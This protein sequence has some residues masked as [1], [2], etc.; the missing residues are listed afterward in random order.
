MLR[1]LL[2]VAL[3]VVAGVADSR[4]AGTDLIDAVKRQDVTAARSLVTKHPDIN[5]TDA[6][7]LTALHWAVQRDNVPLVELLIRSGANVRLTSRYHVSPLYLAATN[8]NTA[9]IGS[10]YEPALRPGPYP[11]CLVRDPQPPRR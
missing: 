4:A 1:P 6:E 10:R 7:G 2:I 5:A 11:R 3:V 8:G 9:V